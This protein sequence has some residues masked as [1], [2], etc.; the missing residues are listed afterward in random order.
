MV[1]F[2]TGNEINDTD[3]EQSYHFNR[4]TTTNSMSF[5]PTQLDMDVLSV[6]NTLVERV[7]LNMKQLEPESVHL[8]H[9]NSSTLSLS[10][11]S[12]NDLT[13]FFNFNDSNDLSTSIEPVCSQLDEDLKAPLGNSFSPP[14]TI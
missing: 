9:Q 2:R 13:N 10:G 1:I 6:V 3:D 14:P 12:S 8:I 11:N 4:L 5:E 7:I